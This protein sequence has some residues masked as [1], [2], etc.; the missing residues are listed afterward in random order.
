MELEGESERARVDG[1]GDSDGLGCDFGSLAE[2]ERVNDDSG[3]STGLVSG[4]EL[5][6]LDG[7][8][9]YGGFGLSFPVGPLPRAGRMEVGRLSA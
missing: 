4:E 2:V 5:V 7:R 6:E 9:V 3:G 8:E 1:G